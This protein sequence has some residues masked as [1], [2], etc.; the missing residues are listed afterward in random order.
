V[1]GEQAALLEFGLPN[2][3]TVGRDVIEPEGKSFGDAHACCRK[4]AKEGRIHH[5]P[6]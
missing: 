6:D 3:Q 1:E 4:K 5:W 2:D